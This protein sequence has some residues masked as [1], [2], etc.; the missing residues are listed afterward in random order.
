MCILALLPRG[1]PFGVK[2]RSWMSVFPAVIHQTRTTVLLKT[3]SYFL[4]NLPIDHLGY[5]VIGAHVL[6]FIYSFSLFSNEFDSLL[7]LWVSWFERYHPHT[8]DL[9][10]RSVCCVFCFSVSKNRSRFLKQERKDD[11]TRMFRSASGVSF[12]FRDVRSLTT[13]QTLNVKKKKK[14]I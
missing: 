1:G 4:I 9:V 10:L 7:W 8:W 14:N 5:S 6:V 12:M 3:V 13:T 11:T 2:A